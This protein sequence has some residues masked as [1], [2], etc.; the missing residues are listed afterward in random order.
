M[1]VVVKCNGPVIIENGEGF[2]ERQSNEWTQ[3]AWLFIL[4]QPVLLR[5]DSKKCTSLVE[6]FKFS[7][8]II[9]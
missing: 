1:V 9:L 4:S 7:L 2:G 6:I 8:G 5:P 3:L